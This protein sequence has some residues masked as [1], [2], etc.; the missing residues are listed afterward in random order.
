MKT[1]CSQTPKL[2]LSSVWGFTEHETAKQA[3]VS[4]ES[5]ICILCISRGNIFCNAFFAG[6]GE[7]IDEA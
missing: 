4:R 6:V 5:I 2:A 3:C 7:V 1:L